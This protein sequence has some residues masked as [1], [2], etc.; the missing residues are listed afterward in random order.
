[1]W[2]TLTAVVHSVRDDSYN[3]SQLSGMEVNL[4]K[5]ISLGKHYT[6][7]PYPAQQ[8]YHQAHSVIYK[9]DV[10]L[11]LNFKLYS[12]TNRSCCNTVLNNV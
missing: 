6:T 5:V 7:M 1:M 9:T 8:S 2:E 11:N 3:G 10:F 12:F 4:P